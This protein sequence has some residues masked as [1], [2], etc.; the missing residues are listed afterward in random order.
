MDNLLGWLPLIGLLT[1]GIALG[2]TARRLGQRGRRTLYLAPFAIAGLTAILIW[3]SPPCQDFLD[4][5]CEH[6]WV[7][8]TAAMSFYLALPLTVLAATTLA[9]TRVTQRARSS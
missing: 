1:I 3:R 8:E 5:P 9:I 7:S 6:N 4:G 2:I